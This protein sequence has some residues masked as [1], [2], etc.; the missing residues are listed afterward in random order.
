MDT[1]INASTV[2]TGVSVS[3][4]LSPTT[5]APTYTGA[6]TVAASGVN[7]QHILTNASY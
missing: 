2:G 6:T 5:G 1:Y 7:N 4:K 3:N